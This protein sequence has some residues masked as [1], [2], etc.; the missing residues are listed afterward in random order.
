VEE[1][2]SLCE[3]WGVDP[4]IEVDG[5][6]SPTTISSVH[7]AGANVFVSASSIFNQHAPIAENVLQLR[8]ALK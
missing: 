1:V 5:G 8:Q 3:K 2:H 7:R 6:I 4:I